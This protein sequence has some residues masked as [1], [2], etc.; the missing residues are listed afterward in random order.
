M[1]KDIS[2][3]NDESILIIG[4]GELGMAIIDAFVE[5]PLRASHEISILLRK[6]EDSKKRAQV[7]KLSSLGFSIVY[8]DI[9]SD[10]EEKLATSFRQFHTIIGAMGMNNAP[11]TQLEIARAVLRAEVQRY[12]PWQFGLDYDAIGRGSAQDLFTEQLDV[13][14]LLRQQE[15]TAWVIVSTGIFM[16][17]LFENSFGVVNVEQKTVRALGGWNNRVTVTAVKDIGRVVAEIVLAAP[18]VKDEVVF[19]AGDTISYEELADMVEQALGTKIDRIEWNL[20]S[21]R[22]DLATDPTNTMKKYRV[23][24][25]EGV[26]VAWDMAATFNTTRGMHMLDAKSLMSRIKYAGQKD[27]EELVGDY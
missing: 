3:Q 13:R 19:V 27:S 5:H 17:F 8:G 7:D 20:E 14:A 9:A 15:K 18:E 11:G 2:P 26:G 23:V 24:F 25:A 12:F 4:A 10:S 6:S 16:S 22:G 21:L 1:S